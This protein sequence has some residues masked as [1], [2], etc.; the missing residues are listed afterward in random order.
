VIDSSPR[1]LL[2]NA[3]GWHSN[4]SNYWLYALLSG[5]QYVVGCGTPNLAARI[6]AALECGL[7]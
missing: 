2:P 3:W 5:S 7:L 1:S 6:E 4:W